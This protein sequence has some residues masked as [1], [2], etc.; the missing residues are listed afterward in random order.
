VHWGGPTNRFGLWAPWSQVHPGQ[1]EP[2]PNSVAER[3][4]G[5]AMAALDASVGNHCPEPS[6]FNKPYYMDDAPSASGYSYHGTITDTN[7]NP[8]PYALLEGNE[9][10]GHNFFLNAD[11]SGKWSYSTP[12]LITQIH[13][14]HFGYATSGN[15]YPVP[16]IGSHIELQQAAPGDLPVY[17]PPSSNDQACREVVY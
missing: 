9:N 7:D 6:D 12:R 8:I 15:H 3:P 14:T 5:F 4:A 10:G 1:A 16:L 17:N 11:A 13:A 2:S